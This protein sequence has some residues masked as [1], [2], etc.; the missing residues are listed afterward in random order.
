MPGGAGR[1][2]QSRAARSGG[3]GRRSR[4][5]HRPARIAVQ[6]FLHGRQQILEGRRRAIRRQLEG[7]RIGR[8]RRRRQ[9][10]IKAGRQGCPLVGVGGHC[11]GDQSDVVVVGGD[12]DRLRGGARSPLGDQ[13]QILEIRLA[14]RRRRYL[15]HG[16]RDQFEGVV[17]RLDRGHGYGRRLEIDL[18][19][20]SG[21]RGIG[22]GG[23]RENRRRIG[24]TG[25]GAGRARSS[26]RRNISC[27]SDALAGGRVVERQIVS[28]DGQVTEPTG[29]QVSRKRIRRHGCLR[30]DPNHN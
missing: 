7:Q 24:R 2:Q 18:L 13:A 4:H 27:G 14:G 26:G 5:R 28:G 15:D 16:G 21:S 6:H 23:Q 19:N 25:D 9:G 11:S 17:R 12:G 22:C 1:E 20:D 8:G 29:A 10:E 30:N 3:C